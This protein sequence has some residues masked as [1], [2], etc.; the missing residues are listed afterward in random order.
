MANI[1]YWIG[2]SFAHHVYL[3]SF[4]GFDIEIKTIF[5]LK[6]IFFLSFDIFA[7]KASVH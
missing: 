1:V 5:S 4:F 6:L 3:S 2:M 7:S